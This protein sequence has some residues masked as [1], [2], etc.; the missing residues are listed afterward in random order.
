M[1]SGAA[2]TVGKAIFDGV[3]EMVEFQ[4]EG[5]ETEITI[6]AYI[7][8][9]AIGNFTDFNLARTGQPIGTSDEIRALGVQHLGELS[10]LETFYSMSDEMEQRWQASRLPIGEFVANERIQGEGVIALGANIKAISGMPQY[11][12]IA[13]V[14]RHPTDDPNY[15]DWS[16]VSPELAAYRQEARE[17]ARQK[18]S[19]GMDVTVSSLGGGS[20]LGGKGATPYRFVFSDAD[21]VSSF[22]AGAEA[23]EVIDELIESVTNATGVHDAWMSQLDDGQRV[24]DEYTAATEDSAGA[25]YD[26]DAANESLAQ[27]LDSVVDPALAKTAV[28]YALLE[29]GIVDVDGS[30]VDLDEQSLATTVAVLTNSKDM[31]AALGLSGAEMEAVLANLIGHYGSLQAAIEAAARPAAQVGPAPSPSSTASTT[32]ASQTSNPVQDAVY[33]AFAYHDES[34]RAW[35]AQNMGE[36]VQTGPNAGKTFQELA[37]NEAYKAAHGGQNAPWFAHGGIVPGPVGA[38]IMAMV[39]GGER[40]LRSGQAGGGTTINITVRGSVM[41]E[42]DLI[43]T[44]R[45]GPAQVGP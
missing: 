19:A 2:I 15:Q 36:V 12:S 33:E 45:S 44:V 9:N 32:A 38:P 26:N 40:I 27:T 8:E 30:F 4:K 10:N 35:I 3:Q 18:A 21:I 11:Q 34:T 37:D 6:R 13:P 7:S 17:R 39:H 25:I 29:A 31:A 1:T 24:F 14:A 42:G 22:G 41:S 28:R 23:A 43:R 5:L 20:T 16:E